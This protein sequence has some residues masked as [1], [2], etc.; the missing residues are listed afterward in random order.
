MG[1]N[2]TL[3]RLDVELDVIIRRA[4]E[5]R[6]DALMSVEELPSVLDLAARQTR[7]PYVD[8][9]AGGAL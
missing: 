1:N 2:P 8:E 5:Q 7:T 9:P 3:K 4:D 6:G